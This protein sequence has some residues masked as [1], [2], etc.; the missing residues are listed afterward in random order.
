MKKSNFNRFV[1]PRF[2][3][4]CAKLCSLLTLFFVS[5]HLFAQQ[6]SLTA[7]GTPYT[8]NFNTYLGT[9]LSIPN[10]WATASAATQV[11]NGAGNGVAAS[12]TGAAATTGG[13]IAY[14]SSAADYAIGTL[15]SG[16]TGNITLTATFVNNTGKTITDLTIA[17][18]FE[19][20]RYANT[21][22]Y[23]VTQTGLGAAVVSG[24][25]QAGVAAGTNGTPTVTPKSI[26]LS[27]LMIE[28]CA[29]F[30]L[31]WMTTDI[32]GSDNGI[33]VDN[34]SIT[35]T[36]CSNNTITV[37]PAAVFPP[38]CV[39]PAG[40]TVSVPFTISALP[41]KF[42]ASNTFT[43]QLSNA[44]GSFATPTTIGTF[45]GN[46]A[47]T[48]TATIPAGLPDGTGYR[49]RVISS[50]TFVN[51][52]PNIIDNGVNITIVNQP[53]ITSAVQ[54]CVAGAGTGRI[55]IAATGSNLEYS[56]NGSTYVASNIFSSLA[57]GTYSVFV[58]STLLTSCAATQSG[59]VI[60]C[61]CTANFGTF[62]W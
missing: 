29:T 48:I 35:P 40:T 2:S 53:V 58:R 44:A 52:A 41:S 36:T 15:R 18:D 28:P 13:N 11:F 51:V 54:S 49:I 3:Y 31:S 21:S 12:S 23:A 10:G 37:S 45:A 22:G 34:F 60:N 47:G 38:L 20:W 33:A 6:I 62:P 8:E 61:S 7:C 30:T 4:P 57:D 16:T 9:G 39:P 56:I 55:T 25:D 1:C 42:L 26:T 32:A 14:G 43:A 59:I 5:S 50:C 46:A 17:Y 24:L 19:Q 27:G